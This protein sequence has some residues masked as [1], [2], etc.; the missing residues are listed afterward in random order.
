MNI[1]FVGLGTMGAPMAMSLLRAGYRLTVH[2]RTR[3]REEP[4][5]AAGAARAASPAEAAQ[6]AEVIITC[7]SDTP[8]VREVVLGERGV[9]HG[10]RRGAVVV[11]MSTI[12]PAATRAMAERLAKREVGLV[13]APVSGGSE[14]A[15]RGTL[16]IMAGGSEAE[17]ETVRPVLLAMGSTVTH[18][19]PV[20]AGQ[21]TKA[22]NQTIIAGVYQSVAEGVALGLGAGLNLERVL[23]AIAG[24]A[25]ASWVLDNRAR[26][27][28]DNSY[29]LG[30]R[31][32]L[33]KK[34]LDIALAEAAELGVSM[35]VAEMV[36]RVEEELIA[37]GHGEKDV[38]AL[39][40]AVRRAAGMD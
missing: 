1:A 3:D 14:G 6:G 36:S 10:A 18:V 37:T 5:A 2:N 17:V 40:I 21:V 8:D 19:G 23:Q 15:E 13:D 33:H 11:D 35:P 22:I 24:G 31:L 30:F 16:A 4:L 28:I 20:G 9:I 12:S 27:M 25:A 34:D 39:A 26:F 38:S 29:P 7:V 32:R